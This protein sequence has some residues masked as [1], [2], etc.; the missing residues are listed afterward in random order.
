MKLWA[1]LT[2][3][4]LMP[5]APPPAL[6]EPEAPPEPV[7]EVE[8][9]PVRTSPNAEERVDFHIARFERAL[10][11]STDPENS[12]VLERWLEHYRLLKAAQMKV[13]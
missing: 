12:K 1:W 13:L 3:A 5:P 9:L 11:Q 10:A 7:V 2:G 6:P 4:D 8:A